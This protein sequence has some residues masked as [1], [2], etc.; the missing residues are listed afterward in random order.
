MSPSSR[1]LLYQGPALGALARTAWLGLRQQ[2]APPPRDV[3]AL[4]GPEVR[5]SIAGPP[6]ALVDAFVRFLGGDPGGENTLPPHLHPQWTFAI[7]AKTLEGLPYPLHRAVNGG[8]RM[9]MNA[10]LP[11][12]ERLSVRGR[13]ERID[14]DGRR[15]VL[16]SRIVTG[17]AKCADALITEYRVVVPLARRSGKERSREPERAPEDAHEVARTRF[18]RRAGLDFAKLTGDFNPIHWIPAYARAS[19][20]RSVILHGFG[21]LAWS[22]A[23]LC[24]NRLAGGT[25]ALHEI[26]GRFTRPLVLPADVGLYARGEDLWVADAPGAPA[27]MTGSFKTQPSGELP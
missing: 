21:T 7:A 2:V 25:G 23:A 27:Y 11:I 20:F 18:D 17:T 14:D 1:F 19:G 10:P 13:L 3:P 26:D 5:R 4:P 12:G 8:C 22:V 6:R 24:R 16:H 15:A 9:Q